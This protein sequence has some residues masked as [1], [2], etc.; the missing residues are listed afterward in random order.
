MAY[1]LQVD[2]AGSIYEHHAI[3]SRIPTASDISH[4]REAASALLP[5]LAMFEL[6]T[7]LHLM[8]HR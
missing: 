8:G 3:S 7:F 6:P 2:I 1:K 5:A 4:A